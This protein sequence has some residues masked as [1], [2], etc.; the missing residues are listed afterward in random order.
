MNKLDISMAIPTVDELIQRAKGL[1]ELIRSKSDQHENE[2]KLSKDVADALRDSGFYKICQS[3]E[4]GGYGMSPSVLWRVSKEI[5][6][7][8]GSTAWILSLT[9]LHPWLAGMFPPQAQDDVFANGQDAIVVALTGNVGRG[10]EATFD[11]ETFTLNGKWTYASG[12]NVA[13]WACVLVEATRGDQTEKHYVLVPAES[14]TI[15]ENSW[16]VLGMKGTGSKDV[17]LENEKV[18]V[19]R[20]VSWEDIHNANY[21]GAERNKDPMY[22]IPHASL[23]AMSVTA[24]IVAVGHGLLDHYKDSL[25]KRMPANSPTPQREDRFSLANLGEAATL[26]DFAFQQLILDVD[27]IY[28]T[29]A[30]GKV[31]TEEERTKYRCHAAFISELTM[32]ATNLI[33]RNLGGS[34]LP[35]GPVERYF[36]D[37]QSMASHFLMQPKPIAELYGRKL[38]GLDLPV[39]ARI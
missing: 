8:D 2:R 39:G 1:C 26:L 12:I 27:T 29:A 16:Q 14:F 11:G 21:P 19:Y 10:V 31:L 35:K 28:N 34:I 20:S 5:G 37:L 6:I 22:Q 17:Y 38:L 9:G 7:G 32:Q 18:P 30:E 4:N 25:S 15:D 33:I 23:F 13:D 3:K 24:A 36:R